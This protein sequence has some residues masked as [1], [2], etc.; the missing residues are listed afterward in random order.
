MVP[1]IVGVASL[2]IFCASIVN[3]GAAVSTLPLLSATVAELP[4]SSVA[5]TL[6][7]YAPSAKSAGTS[8][9]YVPSP[10][11]VAVKV[12]VL[13]PLSVTLMLTVSP[14]ARS[15]V[16]E[17]VGVA[18][19]VKPCASIVNT[20][21]VVSMLPPFSVTVALLPAPSVAVAVTV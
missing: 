6:T 9:V 17:I 3:V 10:C 1:E 21:S 11:T 19:L 18:S 2:V 7:L 20:G 16:P 15:V 4:A 12:W 5:E 8:A 14:G 13:P